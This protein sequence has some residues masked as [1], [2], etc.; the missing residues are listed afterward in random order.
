MA[1]AT[2][3]PESFQ[4]GQSS[5]C[6]V[7]EKM[8][9]ITHQWL[10]EDGVLFSLYKLLRCCNSAEYRALKRVFDVDTRYPTS[11]W[12]IWCLFAL[13]FD[14]AAV[15]LGGSDYGNR[16][17]LPLAGLSSVDEP[18]HGALLSHMGS[19]IV[20]L[21]SF[22]SFPAMV[23]F[24]LAFDFMVAPW[25]NSQEE[26]LAGMSQG[27]M[28]LM[29]FG[30]RS[31]SSTLAWSESGSVS[32]DGSIQEGY[33]FEI[34]HRRSSCSW[35]R[36]GSPTSTPTP[37]GVNVTY[38]GFLN[39]YGFPV[40]V[41]WASYHWWR[42][43]VFKLMAIYQ[44]THMRATCETQGLFLHY[45]EQ[46]GAAACSFC[47][48]DGV[49]YWDS[50]NPQQCFDA[51]LKRNWVAPSKLISD[52]SQLSNYTLD[53]IDLSDLNF[54]MWSPANVDELVRVLKR[55][56]NESF[57][58]LTFGQAGASEPLPEAIWAPW[59][60]F[61]LNQSLVHLTLSN[62][63]LSES[64]LGRI[65]DLF[66]NQS[67]LTH[68]DISRSNIGSALTVFPSALERL[69]ASDSGFNSFNIFFLID[70]LTNN[71]HLMSL[72]ISAS[73]DLSM[74][75][76]CQLMSALKLSA[77]ESLY[78]NQV[79]LF[80]AD[81][82]CV[83]SGWYASSLQYLY[84]SQV[85][86]Y[87]EQFLILLPYLY[88]RTSKGLDVSSNELSYTIIDYMAGLIIH[89]RSLLYLNVAGNQ[90]DNDDLSLIN[91]MLKLANIS[92]LN[93]GNHEYFYE[94]LYGLGQVM[95]NA[96]IAQIMLGGVAHSDYFL[97]GLVDGL[98]AQGAMN[99]SLSALTQVDLS[100]AQLSLQDM[101]DFLSHLY[102]LPLL[103]TL[104]LDHSTFDSVGFGSLISA[105]LLNHSQ[106]KNLHLD[107]MAL[108]ASD[109]HDICSPNVFRALD[110]LTLGSHLMRN[111]E[112]LDCANALVNVPEP[113][114]LGNRHIGIDLPQYIYAHRT[115]NPYALS[116]FS[117]AYDSVTHA[118]GVRGLCQ[119]RVGASVGFFDVNC[120]HSNSAAPAATTPI[121]LL[122]LLGSR[123]C[124]GRFAWLALAMMLSVALVG[125]LK[126]S[127]HESMSFSLR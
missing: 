111:A 21:W 90:L 63:E 57:S 10:I 84:L 75:N 53:H 15:Y 16:L 61:M 28:S 69:N 87:D 106:L 124:G 125:M 82:S 101:Q 108:D 100:F 95:V 31:Y 78:L 105:A 29:S 19:N 116:Y 48:F 73:P 117:M 58:S 70:Y 76:V 24:R 80:D 51:I 17:Y 112:L 66:V 65:N 9:S 8:A 44:N 118:R 49:N 74:L 104:V 88:N 33:Q 46:I 91:S 93:L 30:S 12:T 7:L 43:M 102:L 25:S 72:D 121:W 55:F 38:Q 120:Q 41:V 92:T 56:P 36:V 126:D 5:S 109:V 96:S 110:V 13:A 42:L 83:G 27:P 45:F 107:G 85:S 4:A 98:I 6:P 11:A 3:G 18:R 86:L 64:D 123:V 47:V 20:Q 34:H 60:A 39:R 50:L 62:I 103:D 1:E 97:R 22:Y 26:D 122:C 14:M 81:W 94:A 114:R 68:L 89:N 119:A 40:A 127:A 35:M 77:L 32:L 113:N 54:L 67:R 71:T 115:N 2:G 59:F 52:L 37:V 79:D 99:Q 23:F